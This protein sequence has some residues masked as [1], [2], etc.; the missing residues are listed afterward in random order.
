MK[1]KECKKCHRQ[2]PE[3]YKYKYCEC[4][5]NEQAQDTKKGA[6]V[7]IA[8]GLGAAGLIKKFLKK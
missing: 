8:V 5:R 1:S 7:L 3:G 6:A 4:C 2:L